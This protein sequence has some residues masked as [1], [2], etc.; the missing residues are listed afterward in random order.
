MNL[1]Q[2]T[3]LGNLT[4]DP[5][6]KYLSSSGKDVALVNFGLAVNRPYKKD[7]EWVNEV[8][9]VECEAW[10][11]GAERLAKQVSKGS[12]LLIS[13]SLKMDEWE[14]DGKK[15]SKLRVRVNKFVPVGKPSYGA[16]GHDDD[17]A[18]SSSVPS[19]SRDNS[20][21]DNDIPF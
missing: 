11:S 13:G 3:L 17:D 19:V 18:G 6:L 9:Y 8:C 4:R 16:D 5:E 14:Q 1:N 12:P 10:D 21:M 20:E 2:V 15:R 7:N